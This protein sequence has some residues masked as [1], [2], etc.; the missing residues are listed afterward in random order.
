RRGA[1]DAAAGSGRGDRT[2]DKPFACRGFRRH[3]CPRGRLLR[4]KR[5]CWSGPWVERSVAAGFRGGK[6]GR[7]LGLIFGLI[8][9]YFGLGILFG[10]VLFTAT[11]YR[12]YVADPP[13]ADVT[14]VIVDALVQ[15]L[16][17]IFLWLP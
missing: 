2:P 4:R 12:G 7:M 15:G 1:G 8:R 16:F 17:R 3:S 6:G 5:S 9:L 10:L 13:V 14:D 11:I